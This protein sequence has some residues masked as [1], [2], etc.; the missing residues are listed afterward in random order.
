MDEVMNDPC[1]SMLVSMAAADA[2]LFQST[3]P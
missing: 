1:V 3:A 2:E